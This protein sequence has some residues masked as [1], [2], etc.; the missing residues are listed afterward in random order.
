MDE[1]FKSLKTIT[2]IPQAP[3]ADRIAAEAAGAKIVVRAPESVRQFLAGQLTLGELE[4]IPK[5]AQYAM[6]EVGYR[7]FSEGRLDDAE[8]V[9]RGLLALDPF[10]AYFHTVLGTIAKEC[11]ELE[12]AETHLSRAL[13]INPYA[14][15][16]FGQRGETRLLAG[17]LAGASSDLLQAI[18]LDPDG[19]E[20]GTARIR[21]LAGAVAQQLAAL[22]VD[23]S[24]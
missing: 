14:A 24:T 12:T 17:D 7:F 9:F 13:E 15:H 10:D 4:G 21:A 6:A 18:D 19:S 3:E 8:K 1:D 16:A 20:P 5:A 22:S 23:S 11:K 2:E